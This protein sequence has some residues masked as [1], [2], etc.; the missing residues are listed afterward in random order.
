M[1]HPSPA[2]VGIGGP[3]MLLFFMLGVLPSLLRDSHTV[4]GG[5][6]ILT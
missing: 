1:N 5:T 2:P 4:K 3:E 6:T